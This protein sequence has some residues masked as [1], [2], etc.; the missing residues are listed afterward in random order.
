M[1]SQWWRSIQRRSFR[2][3]CGAVVA[4][5]WSLGLV[6]CPYGFQ[7]GTLPNVKTVAILPFENDTSEPSLT[8]EVSEA[9]R[10]ALEG[11]LGLRIATEQA[12]DALV[13]GRV[14]RYD[15]D[16][17]LAI[18]PGVGTT[19]VPKRKVQLIV[20]VEIVNQRDGTTVWRGQGLSVEG[21]YAPPADR[22][23]RKIAIDKLVTQIVDGAQS[24]W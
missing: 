22:E 20:D 21:E 5:A 7:G 15:P 12:A 18:L 14:V 13:R 4:S 8:Q 9:V 6:G 24:Q 17:P 1:S 19:T 10:Q 16:V 3:L 23:G 11:R 2:R